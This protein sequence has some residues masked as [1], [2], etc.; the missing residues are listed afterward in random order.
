MYEE[1]FIDQFEKLRP[2]SRIMQPITFADRVK[3]LIIGQ[4]SVEYKINDEKK[5]NHKKFLI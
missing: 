1:K 2:V 3:D 5:L 4:K